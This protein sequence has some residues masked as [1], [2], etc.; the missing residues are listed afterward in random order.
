MA[1]TITRVHMALS[2]VVSECVECVTH[3]T[4]FFRDYE[5]HPWSRVGPEF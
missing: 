3:F 1:I 4:E 5:S 2:P